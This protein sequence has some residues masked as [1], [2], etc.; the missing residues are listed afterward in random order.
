LFLLI[1]PL[2]NAYFSICN[3]IYFTEQNNLFS[4]VK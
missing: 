3:L 2:V 4:S 1:V